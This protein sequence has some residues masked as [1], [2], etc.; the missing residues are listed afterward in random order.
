MPDRPPLDLDGLRQAARDFS[1]EI[2]EQAMPEL[3]GVDNGKTIGTNIEHRFQS[4]LAGRFHHETGNSASGIDLPGMNTDIKTT[5]IRQPQSSCPFKNAE[6]K[7]YGLGYH[8]LVFVYEKEDD[9]ADSVARLAISHCI[10]LESARTA[11]YQTTRGL[12]GILENDGNKADIEAFLIERNLP[13]DEIG[14][15]RLSD[16]I[17]EEPPDQGYLT[18]SNALQWRLQYGRAITFASDDERSGVLELRG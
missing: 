9:P 7:V 10:F 4:F 6:Q 5:S 11:D 15:D 18:I 12:R 17:I 2:H 3:Y 14:L 13:L 8:L 1:E 16:R